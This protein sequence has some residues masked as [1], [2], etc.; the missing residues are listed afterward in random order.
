MNEFEP[1][2]PIGTYS[3]FIRAGDTIYISGQIALDSD[4]GVLISESVKEQVEQTF[5]NL[6]SVVEAAGAMLRH[7]V[8]ITIHVTD[9]TCYDEVNDVMQQYFTAPFPARA[10]VEVSRLPKDAL[11]EMDA[12][13]VLTE[14]K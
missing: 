2:K 4:R 8:K 12:I 11:I 7:V 13:V 10:L 1:M 9:L 3:P 6:K 14:S 5:K